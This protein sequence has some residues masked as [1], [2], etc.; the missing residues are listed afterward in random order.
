MVKDKAF[1]FA[2]AERIREVRTL[3]FQFPANTPQVLQDFENSF[4]QPDT[5]RETRLFAK[6]DQVVSSR[7]RLTE[8]LNFTNAH[9]ANFNP[10]SNATGLPSTRTNSGDAALL[11][12][13]SDTAL[14]E[15]INAVLRLN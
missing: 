12:G 15:A 8:E 3:N 5:D 1:W 7:Q 11:A 2:S 13:I 14:L 10:L 6:F 9:V 4:N